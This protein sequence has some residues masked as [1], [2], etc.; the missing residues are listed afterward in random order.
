M[1]NILEVIF[2]ELN[3]NGSIGNAERIPFTWDEGQEPHIKERGKDIF[4]IEFRFR[5]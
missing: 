1:Q 4:P 2:K 3:T 5:V